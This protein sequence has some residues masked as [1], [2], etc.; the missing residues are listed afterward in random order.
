MLNLSRDR[1]RRKKKKKR[2]KGRLLSLSKPRASM[3]GLT[4]AQAQGPV[5]VSRASFP[6][7]E[8][9]LAVPLCKKPTTSVLH[10]LWQCGA[11]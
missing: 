11:W 10:W 4:H 3:K 2:T 5:V 9:D 6:S 1:R 8:G 7:E